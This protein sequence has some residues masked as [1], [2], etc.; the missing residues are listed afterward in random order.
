MSSNSKIE[1]MYA[2]PNWASKMLKFVTD[3]VTHL[4]Q[5]RF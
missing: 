1:N 2:F 3:Y 5:L 4:D